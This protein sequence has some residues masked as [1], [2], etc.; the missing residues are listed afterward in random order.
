MGHAL[1]KIHAMLIDNGRLLD[2]R[3]LGEPATLD[4]CLDDETHR[5]GWISEGS[6]Y[7]KYDHAAEALKNAVSWGKFA[8]LKSQPFKIIN[9][10]DSLDDVEAYLEIE[11][12]DAWLD[13]R[14]QLRA[15]DL[16]SVLAKRK[17]LIVTEYNTI[18][19]LE[20]RS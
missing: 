4:V 11:W 3:P 10:A 8:I 16:L 13:E 17:Q 1:E 20:K 12:V 9:Y 7:A 19:L 2:I 6:D 15:R 18:V 14:V 5:A